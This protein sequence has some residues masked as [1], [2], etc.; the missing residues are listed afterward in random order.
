MKESTK[1]VWVKMKEPEL[2]KVILE[3]SEKYAPSQIGIILR[4][5]YGTRMAQNTIP[6]NMLYFFLKD[7]WDWRALG[8]QNK[9]WDQFG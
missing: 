5:Q 3:L 2:K 1:P 7:S 8:S 6:K 4:D 9:Y